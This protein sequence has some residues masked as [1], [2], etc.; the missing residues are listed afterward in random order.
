[1]ANANYG[2][3]I[4]GKQAQSGPEEMPKLV[5]K[6]QVTIKGGLGLSINEHMD[7]TTM[8]MPFQIE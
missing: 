2:N 5:E 6:W 4:A 7:A 8:Y 1:L 3:N